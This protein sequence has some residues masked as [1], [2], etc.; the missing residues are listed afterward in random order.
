[1]KT[2]FHRLFIVLALQALSTLNLQLSTCFA[3]G[4][5]TPPG[6]PAP[7][8]LTLNQ[9]EPRTPVDA[10]HT[11]GDAGDLFVISQPGSYYLTGNIIVSSGNAISIN[12]NGVTLDLNGSTISTTTGDLGFPGTAILLVGNEANPIIGN[13]DITISNGH[14]TGGVTY[15]A[16]NYNGTGFFT[17]ISYN[18]TAGTPYNVRVTGVSVSGCNYYG[19]Y[20]GTSNSTVVESCTVKTVGNYGIYA[21]SVSHSTAFQCGTTAITADIASDCY[22]YST[23]GDG[24]DAFAAANNCYGNSDT[25][26]GIYVNNGNAINCNG[27]SNGNGNGLFA[28]DNAE[29]CYG[30]S[31]TGI[32]INIEQGNAN[33]CNGINH[34]GDNDGIYVLLGNA[35]NCHGSSSDNDGIFVPEGNANNCFGVSSSGFAYGLDVPNGSAIGCTG[36]DASDYG[37]KAYIAIGCYSS[38]GDSLIAHPYNMP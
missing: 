15:S 32:G 18:V 36:Y 9:V 24:L 6:A 33:N 30:N 16:G 31:N 4:S 17:G 1:M 12:T 22:A 29:N 2:K 23:G 13:T 7:T 20:L 37:I 25:D 27:N 11:P 28:S 26:N 8:M 21:S 19:I 3:Q 38:F 34:G 5:L 10:T 35:N 14:I